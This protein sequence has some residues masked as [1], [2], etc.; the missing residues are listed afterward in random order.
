MKPICRRKFLTKA[1]GAALATAVVP[2]IGSSCNQTGKKNPTRPLNFI[3]ILIDDMGY[4]DAACY[5][6]DFHHTPNV[7]RLAASGMKFTDAYA[8]CPVCSPTRASI[9]T[10]K[11]PARL[12]LTDYLVGHRVDPN[13]PIIYAD[14]IHHLPLGEIPIAE[15]LKPK[16]YV[17]AQI[18]KWH[19]GPEGYYPEQQGFDVNIGGTF[20]GMP[21][22]YF[23]PGWGDNPPIKA[24]PGEYL[25]DRLTEAA[26]QFIE[27]NQDRPFFLYLSHYA[28][29]IPIQAKQPMI[30][31]YRGALRPGLVHDNPIYA[32]MLESVDQSVGRVMSKLKELGIDDN[33][34]IFFTS[35]NGG[36]S[37]EEGPHTPATDNHPLRAG[38]GYLY[39]GGIR[40]P[41]IVRWPGVTEPESVCREPVISVDYLPTIMEMAGIGPPRDPDVDGISIVPLLKGGERLNREAIYWHY[42]HFSNQGGRPGA[43]VRKGNYKLIEFYEGGRLE[44]YDLSQD[45][46]EKNDLAGSM[47]EKAEELRVM[48]EQWRQDLDANMPRPN[49]DYSSKEI[50]GN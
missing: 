21:R 39:E 29:H 40:E 1:G 44:L 38:K 12:H 47:P 30:E 26:E 7:D 14:Y 33:T 43:A 42:P 37:V 19:L 27:D 17:S 31:L 5:G 35:D 2:L 11:Y 20:S 45:I 25:T 34:V 16:G 28:V 10:G 15:V 18:G 8:A 3:F 13:S 46:G 36:L 32:A 22:D 23:F 9:M 50:P 4:S 6:S 24:Q 41:L 49:P 48:L